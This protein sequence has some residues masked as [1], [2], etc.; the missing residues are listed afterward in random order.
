MRKPR[1]VTWV[2]V[3][4]GERARILESDTVDT[5]LRQ[6]M[7]A[8]FFN[9]NPPTREQGTDR[10]GRT[11]DRFGQGRHAME[12][13]ADWHRFEKAR[14]AKD[15]ARWLKGATNDNA[16]DRLVLIAPPQSLGDLRAE[17]DK[18]TADRVIAELRKTGR[19]G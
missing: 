3:A 1:R 11:K 12:P 9:V 15:I 10:P 17:L 7:A 8:D 2:L 13:R 4:D 18:Q 6:A 19:L 14:F 5:S 16:F